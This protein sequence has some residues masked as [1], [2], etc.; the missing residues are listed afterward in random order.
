MVE[1]KGEDEEGAVRGCV[2]LESHID[3]VEADVLTLLGLVGLKQ[4]ACHLAANEEALTHVGHSDHKAGLPIVGGY[5]CM[6]AET[7]GLC[8]LLGPGNLCQEGTC[9]EDFQDG[10]EHQLGNKKHN[11]Q[12]ALLTDVAE[13]IANG[14]LGLEGE[15]EGPG[16]RVHLYHAGGVV[17]RGAQLQQ[18]PMGHGDQ[19]PHHTKEEPGACEGSRE[20]QK[21]VAPLHV[22]EGGP[23]V[24]EVEEALVRDVLHPHVAATIF[25]EDSPPPDPWAHQGP[26]FRLSGLAVIHLGNGSHLQRARQH[27][28]SYG[29]SP[30]DSQ[31]P[32]SQWEGRRS[33]HFS[34]TYL[35]SY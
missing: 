29:R 27:N 34:A 11:G 4:F 21:L 18:V 2:H 31:P 10:G 6:L 13:A 8:P 30:A 20:E 25:C 9:D 14:G 17:G 3:L 5:D 1:S 33:I 16:E 23:Q 15:E 12:W 22:N 7:D 26:A 28:E 32:P 24:L 19:V 35:F